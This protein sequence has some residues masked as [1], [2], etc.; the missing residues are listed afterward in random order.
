MLDVSADDL[1]AYGRHGYLVSEV[2]E[3]VTYLNRAICILC[4][5]FS[6]VKILS[7]SSTEILH[8]RAFSAFSQ[9]NNLQ[10]GRLPKT[11][12]AADLPHLALVSQSSVSAPTLE[13][14]TRFFFCKQKLEE[15][16]RVFQPQVLPHEIDYT[17][18]IDALNF[19]KSRHKF[20]CSEKERTVGPSRLID[21]YTSPPSLVDSPPSA[22]YVALSYVWG[23]NGNQK[24]FQKNYRA[25]ASGLTDVPS[26]CLPKT[27]SD[28]QIVVRKLGYR[29]LWLLVQIA[30]TGS[31]G[32]PPPYV[33][34]YQK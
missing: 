10:L 4:R 26:A 19:C 22:S 12:L 8:L 20:L 14:D 5:F 33:K 30:N 6:I 7:A 27:I 21:C 9:A 24:S 18:I 34:Q 23:N 25:E 17:S 32:F 13:S 31:L 28:A 3:K 11:L 1:Q 29:Y 2:D 15:S 16:H